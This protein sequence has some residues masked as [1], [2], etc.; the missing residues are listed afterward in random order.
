MQLS[1]LSS[2][3]FDQVDRLLSFDESAQMLGLSIEAFRLLP[4]LGLMPV[5][6]TRLY[7]LAD[8]Q[9]LQVFYKEQLTRSEV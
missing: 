1:L 5:Q 9:Q 6:G 3:A 4:K 7:R 8:I 2:D